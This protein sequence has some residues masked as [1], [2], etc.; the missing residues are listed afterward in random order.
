MNPQTANPATTNSAPPRNVPNLNTQRNRLPTSR[1][2]QQTIWGFIQNHL[3]PQGPPREQPN[4]VP[5]LIPENTQPTLNPAETPPLHPSLE[6]PN[7]IPSQ[8]NQIA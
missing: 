2:C 4:P 7:Q 5:I 6:I 3:L 1:P 8:H